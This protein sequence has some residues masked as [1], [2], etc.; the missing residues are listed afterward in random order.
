MNHFFIQ[1][2][3]HVFCLSLDL[4]FSF[5]LFMVSVDEINKAFVTP[6]RKC[7][8]VDEPR[9]LD[10]PSKGTYPPRSRWTCVTLIQL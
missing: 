3:I 4:F 8:R 9:I 1:K 5:F 10:F 6:R 7:K 2:I